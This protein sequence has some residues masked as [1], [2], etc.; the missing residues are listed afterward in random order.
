MNTLFFRLLDQKDKAAPLSEAVEAVR[1]GH[2][3]N[4]V[5]HAVDPSSF[6]QVPGFRPLPTG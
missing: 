5:V 6:R 1:R 3:L 2:S 4:A